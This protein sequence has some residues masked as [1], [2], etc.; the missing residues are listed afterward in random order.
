MNYTDKQ[1]SLTDVLEKM[2]MVYSPKYG[3]ANYLSVDEMSHQTVRREN[4]GSLVLANVIPMYRTNVENTNVKNHNGCS[5]A[6]SKEKSQVKALGEFIERYCATNEYGNHILPLC[7]NSYDEQS[8]SGDCL[9]LSDLIDFDDSAYTA[10]GSPYSHYSHDKIISWVPGTELTS[11]KPA[12]IPAQKAFLGIPFQNGE[13]VHIQCL[14]TGLACGSS[15]KAAAASGILE[16]IERDSFMLTWLLRLPG[17][18]IIVDTA[19]DPELMKLY[20]HI[21]NHLVGDD[22]LY[23]YD[24]SRTNGVYS[25]VTFIRNDNPE[26]FGLITS[27]ASDLNPERALLKSLEELCLCQ[28]YAYSRLYKS[29]QS[30][31]QI[32][33][34]QIKDVT[35]L[36]AHF[37]YY[38]TG[39]RSHEI[40]FISRSHESIRLSEMP[41]FGTPDDNE[42]FHRLVDI[43]KS[44]GKPVYS[45]NLT[46][47]EIRE[48]GL[49]VI[50]A[51]IPGYNDLDNSHEMRLL[52]NKR[53]L[54]FRKKYNRQINDAPHPFS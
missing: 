8:K 54:E 32:R 47:P 4:L 28:S 5:A 24:I 34:M 39:T 35:T 25:F 51:I 20:N 50:K 6:L 53:L 22:R 27:A 30:M 42:R 23:I 12:W 29:S 26:S 31:K 1:D 44:E 18:E 17:K 15:E 16:I 7:Y 49:W 9:D 37:F 38:G 46:R 14:S 10:E 45:V 19:N 21:I 43:F 2:M 40:D 36:H 13:Q 3:L 52:A 48:C 33:A 11:G 41:C